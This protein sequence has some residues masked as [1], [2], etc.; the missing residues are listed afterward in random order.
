MAAGTEKRTQTDAPR[1]HS[2]RIA[3]SLAR[4]AELVAQGKIKLGRPKGVLNAKTIAKIKSKEAFDEAVRERAGLLADD[5]FRSSRNGDTQAAKVL[6]EQ[7]FGKAKDNS[8]RDN[9]AA[10]FSLLAFAQRSAQLPPVDG[11]KDVAK[12][13]LPA[14]EVP[15]PRPSSEE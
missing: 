3:K 2:P 15:H 1:V 9:V 11:N 4:R 12:N 13:E 6:L 5:L 8:L 7:T 10:V 14:P